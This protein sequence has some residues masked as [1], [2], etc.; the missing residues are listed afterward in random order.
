MRVSLQPSY[1]LHSRPYRDS[2]LILEVFCAEHGRLSLVSKGA[3]RRSKG[4]SSVALLQPFIPLLLSFS[5][6]SEM[7]TLTHVEPAGVAPQ[8]RGERLFSGMY[9]NEL[10]MRLLHR[11]DPH[12]Q[13]FANYG[14]ALGELGDAEQVEVCLRRFELGLLD[15]LGY[16]FSLAE[17]GLS[18]EAIS[19]D[20]W[21]H[22]SPDCG[23]VAGVKGANPARPAYSGA[24]LLLLSQGKY[25]GE[26]RSVA[27][28]LMREVLAQYLGSE[29]LKSRDL[30]HG[31]S[32]QG[33]ESQ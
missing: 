18:G 14:T 3:R 9:I 2:S 17:D 26:A 8:L 21:Y 33:G 7:K 5:G 24:E 4:G 19:E 10:L 25:G 29:P 28:R 13:L 15:E 16:G 30:F 20:G 6:R 22:F 1:I 31:R 11:H 12:P 23:L 32:P 27:R